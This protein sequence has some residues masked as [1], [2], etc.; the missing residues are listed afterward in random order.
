MPESFRC[1]SNIISYPTLVTKSVNWLA[2]PNHYFVLIP[3]NCDWYTR[4]AVVPF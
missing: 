4:E 1:M 3:R 2:I